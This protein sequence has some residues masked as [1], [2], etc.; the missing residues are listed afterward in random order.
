MYI[1][2]FVCGVL[3]TLLVEFAVTIVYTIVKKGE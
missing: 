1:N 2:P 3:A